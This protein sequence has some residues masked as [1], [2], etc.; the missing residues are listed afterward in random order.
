MGFLLTVE[1]RIGDECFMAMGDSREAV[2]DSGDPAE[3]ASAE[4]RG[5]VLEC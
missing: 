2:R 3:T 1:T 4:A 5:F